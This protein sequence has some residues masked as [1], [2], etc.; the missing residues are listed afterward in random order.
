MAATHGR[1]TDGSFDQSMPPSAPPM[2][3]VPPLLKNESAFP[4][5]QCMGKGSAAHLSHNHASQGQSRP[6]NVFLGRQAR[7]NSLPRRSSTKERNRRN[8]TRPPSS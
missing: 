1:L 8:T 2:E 3:M 5:G 7:P 4:T 6:K